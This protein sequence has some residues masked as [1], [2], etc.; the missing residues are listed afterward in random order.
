MRVGLIILAAGGSTRLAAPKQLLPVGGRSF[1]RHAADTAL[2]SVCRPVVVVLGAKAEE[3][4]TELA[5]LDV[6]IVNN[7]QWQRGLGSSIRAGM[8]AIEAASCEAV[9]IM[10]CDQPLVSA[11][12]LNRLVETKAGV[13]AAEYG[14]TVGVPALF[15]A[16]FFAELTALPGD[17]GAKGLLLRHAARIARVPFPEA[18]LDID[19]PEDYQRFRNY[20]RQSSLAD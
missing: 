3:L 1:L 6:T 5:G 7:T 13:A 4:Q 11:Q 16:E 19:T 18:A 8:A 10:L 15:T 9:A 20:E 17:T 12:L 2:A 14:G